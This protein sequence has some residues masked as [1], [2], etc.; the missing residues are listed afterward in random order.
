VP[1]KAVSDHRS[2]LKQKQKIFTKTLPCRARC[3]TSLIS[4]KPQI[5][6]LGECN[7][8][9]LKSASFEITND[10]DLPAT[11][12]P[13]VESGSLDLLEKE[14]FIPPRQSKQCHFEF[15]ARAVEDNYSKRITLLNIFNSHSNVQVEIRAKTVDTHQ[16]LEHSALYK[17]VT[18]NNKKQLQVYFE[19]CISNMPNMRTFTIHNLCQRDLTFGFNVPQHPNTDMEI[20]ALNS[21]NDTAETD[22]GRTM[23]GDVAA[24]SMTSFKAKRMNAKSSSNF[25]SF[26]GSSATD[27]E[28]GLDLDKI[29][30]NLSPT[31]TKLTVPSG[32]HIK[33]SSSFG[34]E[35]DLLQLQEMKD[36]GGG[37]IDSDRRERMNQLP[38]SNNPSN[39]KD[40]ITIMD[41]PGFPFAFLNEDSES[42]QKHVNQSSKV[43]SFISSCF[44]ELQEV[45]SSPD[46]FPRP[47]S[48]II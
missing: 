16:V 27:L 13:V 44:R 40:F 11:I 5:L 48:A 43:I 25:L 30:R 37:T 45:C 36:K 3:C 6:E 24:L 29:R 35:A 26:L 9:D 21:R 2:D 33:R 46:S 39:G 8:G 15:V 17:I 23:A 28:S 14:I 34:H 4:A 47:D 12:L 1:L 18:K 7:I 38:V 42:H 32:R 10:S 41:S 31:S 22:M 20:Y 19:N